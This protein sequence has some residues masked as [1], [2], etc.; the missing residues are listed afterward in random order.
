MGECRVACGDGRREPVF[1][2][3]CHPDR[4]LITADLNNGEHRA[5]YFFSR[6]PHGLRYIGEFGWRHVI[7]MIKFATLQ[8]FAPSEMCRLRLA[9]CYILPYRVHLALGRHRA[10]VHSLFHTSADL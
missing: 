2:V 9:D 7:A 6:N 8:T 5:E 10:E 4:F 3:V 1:G